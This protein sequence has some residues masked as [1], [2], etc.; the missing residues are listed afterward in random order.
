[1]RQGLA[2]QPG[3]GR[4]GQ[5]QLVSQFCKLGTEVRLASSPGEGSVPGGL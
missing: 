5:R 2:V 1:M 4:G 3:D